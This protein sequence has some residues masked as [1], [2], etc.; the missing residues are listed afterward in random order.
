MNH[1]YPLA[2]VMTAET[3]PYHPG[4]QSLPSV[5]TMIDIDHFPE[6]MT[7]IYLITLLVIQYNTI[8]YNII[9]NNVRS[10]NMENV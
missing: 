5:G 6:T 8:H 3:V 7:Q 2:L 9:K 1:Q 10:G 4:F